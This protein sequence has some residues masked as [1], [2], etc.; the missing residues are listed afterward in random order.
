M[1]SISKWEIKC[2]QKHHTA[3]IGIHPSR[4]FHIGFHGSNDKATFQEYT[5]VPEEIV[6]KV[7]VCSIVENSQS[8]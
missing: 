4:S 8:E 7:L 3:F 1:L 6:A 2:K 5:I